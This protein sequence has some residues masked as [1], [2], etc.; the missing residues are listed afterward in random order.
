[1][2]INREQQDDINQFHNY[3]SVVN[4]FG[5]KAVKN[6]ISLEFL[7]FKKTNK[8]HPSGLKQLILKKVPPKHLDLSPS[9]DSTPRG[10]SITGTSL[11]SSISSIFLSPSKLEKVC[12]AKLLKLKDNNSNY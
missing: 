9:I 1:M 3:H 6:K 8:K 12:Q 2:K 4:D 5:A 10:V 11:T 7:D